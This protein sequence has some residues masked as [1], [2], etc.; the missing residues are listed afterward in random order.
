MT[1]NGDQLF[2]YPGSNYLRSSSGTS[3]DT[4]TLTF[5]QAIDTLSFDIGS[6]DGGN[7]ETVVF[8]R[9][10]IVS[11]SGDVQWG[12]DSVAI[13]NGTTLSSPSIVQGSA[14]VTFTGL[15]GITSFTFAEVFLRHAIYYD[16][17][18]AT[19]DVAPVP[20]PAGLPLLLAALGTLGLTWRRKAS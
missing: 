20:L 3:G 2:N 11:A 7:G 19:T 13:L 1:A 6:L 4:L 14:N 10:P 9:A 8:D 5:S 18:T 16:N 12:V 17:F 15:G